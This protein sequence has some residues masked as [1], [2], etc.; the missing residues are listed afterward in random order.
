MLQWVLHPQAG[1]CSE[2][3]ATSRQTLLHLTALLTLLQP[4]PGGVG[5][6]ALPTRV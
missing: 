4:D 2:E 3:A 5:A 1:M 6:A